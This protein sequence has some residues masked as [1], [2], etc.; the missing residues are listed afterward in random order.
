[1]KFRNEHPYASVWQAICLLHREWGDS[2]QRFL[3]TFPRDEPS[4]DIHYF[5]GPY[6]S[7]S[8]TVHFQITPEVAEELRSSRLVR[9][10]PKW[11]YTSDL[12]WLPTDELD[13]IF[14]ETCLPRFQART[15]GRS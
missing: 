15:Y 10:Q 12:T 5:H 7:L 3:S 4:I 11:G 1:V 8:S 13:R 6:D 9:G 14:Y 2:S